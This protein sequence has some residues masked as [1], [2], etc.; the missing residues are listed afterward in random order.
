MDGSQVAVSGSYPPSGVLE[1]LGV[2]WLDWRAFVVGYLGDTV[3]KGYHSRYD[4][5]DETIP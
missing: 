2:N 3:G 5:D 1:R 4:T